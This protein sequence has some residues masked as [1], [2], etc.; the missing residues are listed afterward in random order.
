M[1]LMPTFSC[2]LVS[3]LLKRVVQSLNDAVS[4]SYKIIEKVFFF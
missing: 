4:L 3:S 1:D 2:L